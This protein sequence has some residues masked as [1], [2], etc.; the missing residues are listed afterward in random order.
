[1]S[2]Y[3]TDRRRLLR[4]FGLTAATTTAAMAKADP[5]LGATLGYDE[6]IGVSPTT[7]QAPTGLARD[8]DAKST[9]LA[10]IS[11]ND[12]EIT[13]L[14]DQIWQYAELSLREWRSSLAVAALLRK[15][16]FAIEWGA[17][18][19]PATF[20]ATYGSGGPVL[21][22]NAEYDALPGLSQK[23]GVS[24]H[25]PLVYNYD[26]YGP[27]YGAGHGDAHNTLGVG[28]AAAAIAVSQAIR[29]NSGTGR[30]PW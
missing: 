11:A 1:M 27:T 29:R 17:A 8:S 13:G 15:Y 3:E 7:Y 2:S 5:V 16:G 23:S 12:A 21:G 10:W 14:S 30:R 20:V 24:T 28:G 25:D 4:N 6:K 26:A 22:F 18:G 19:F 9:A